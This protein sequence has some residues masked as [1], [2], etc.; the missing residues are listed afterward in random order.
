MENSALSSISEI[1]VAPELLGFWRSLDLDSPKPG[2][3][4]YEKR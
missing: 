3:F 1:A 4:G 2:D